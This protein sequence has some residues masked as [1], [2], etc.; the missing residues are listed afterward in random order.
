MGKR[1]VP[2]DQR[3]K[4]VADCLAAMSRGD[5]I[6]KYAEQCGVPESNLRLWMAE[7]VDAA[8]YARARDMQADAAFDRVH[9]LSEEVLTAPPEMAS[10]YRAAMQAE[11]WRAGKL[12]PRYS[13]KQQVEHSG[14]VTL[15]VEYGDEDE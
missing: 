10:A 15:K 5:S 3:A 1:P 14:A 8:H 7:D 2:K 4:H 11:Q 6:R 13:D 9:A 12:A